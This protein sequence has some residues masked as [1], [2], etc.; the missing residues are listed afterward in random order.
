[1]RYGIVLTT[2]IGATALFGCGDTIF[3]PIDPDEVTILMNVTGGFAGVDYSFEVD[4]ESG[5]V[6]GVMCS[7]GCAFQPGQLLER[8]S[9]DAVGDL[10]LRFENAGAL[11][12][13][14][15]DF[16]TECCDHFVY[17]VT[18]EHAGGT[19]TMTGTASRM[20]AA[21]SVAVTDVA[22]LIHGQKAALV[23]MESTP[24][25]W[26]RDSYSL[27][28]I[29]VAGQQLTTTA[30]YGGGCEVH[31]FDL[32]AWGG[33]LES[34]PVQVEVLITH[35]DHDDMCDALPTVELY[36]SLRPIVEA[37]EEAYGP[38]EAGSRT[39]ILR[40]AD[41]EGGETRFVDFVF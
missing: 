3:G 35:E 16:G 23:R 25:E 21:L 15:L 26:P 38:G 10:A 7:N 32:V 2:I 5:E 28:E 1:M 14:G 33:W 12:F 27:G 24:A 4:G 41:P 39:L 6:R 20:P 36:Y 22:A 37:Y 13:D 34:N 8:L 9:R 31:T 29:N 40:I 30:T 18:Y 17:T 19:S 11:Q